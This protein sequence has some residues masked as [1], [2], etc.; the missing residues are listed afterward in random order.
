[1]KAH[2]ETTGRHFFLKEKNLTTWRN[3]GKSIQYLF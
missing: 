2:K 1:M 3:W